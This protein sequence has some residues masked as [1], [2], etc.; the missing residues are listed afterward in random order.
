M[1]SAWITQNNCCK[2]MVVIPEKIGIISFR[3]IEWVLCLGKRQ[4]TA[5]SHKN[6]EDRYIYIYIYMRHTYSKKHA[7]SNGS[8][9]SKNLRTLFDRRQHIS[10]FDVLHFRISMLQ[11][12]IIIVTSGETWTE[13]IV[14]NI[15]QCFQ[16]PMQNLWSYTI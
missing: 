13:R 6:H 8:S 4:D 11:H 2:I 1:L 10:Q 3:L 12:G 5:N 9:R 7:H 16:N 15:R 14:I